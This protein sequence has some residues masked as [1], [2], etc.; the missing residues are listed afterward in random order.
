M[1]QPRSIALLLFAVA[2]VA[3]FGYLALG[4]SHLLPG[5]SRDYLDAGRSLLERGTILD[6]DGLPRTRRGPGYVP[7]VALLGARP[8]ALTA[9]NHLFGALCAPLTFFL[10]LPLSRRIAVFAG[11]LVALHPDMV[12]WS[13][14]V[15][16]EPF[17][18]V[19]ML[20]ALLLAQRSRYALAG[21][22]LGYAIVT[23]PIAVLVPIAL[24]LALTLSRK[25]R[26]AV[27]LLACG[28]LFPL[29]WM[30]RNRME[31]GATV[32]TSTAGENLLLWRAG[33]AVAMQD[34][35]FTL[36]LLPSAREDELRHHLFAEVQPRLGRL[37]LDEA[38]VRYGPN[39]T[40]LQIVD[41]S[42]SMGRH[43][44][45][46]TPLGFIESTIHSFVHMLC[47][48]AEHWAL[49]GLV[50]SVPLA[51]LALAGSLQPRA[52]LLSATFWSLV[53]TTAGPEA[54][55]YTRFR[56]PLLPLMAILAAAAVESF[57]KGRRQT[58]APSSPDPRLALD[59]GVTADK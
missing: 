33:G 2:L 59:G 32:L 20:A 55:T 4:D 19:L 16:S 12:V 49:L 18:L 52:A 31:A 29:L 10:A 9:L 26:A 27:V 36:S 48:P 1:Q 23:R 25:R 28:Y 46:T 50:I 6:S 53:I 58:D 3:H 35:G 41:V 7:V 11:S 51:L 38:R 34:R 57:R 17:F 42:R 47:D 45:L 13:D 8:F 43:L 30:A 44:I 24:A 56:L 54:A 40:R 39:P 5:D 14:F 37:A 22:V 21:L 15:L